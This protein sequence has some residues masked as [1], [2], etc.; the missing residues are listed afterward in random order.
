[1]Q[2]PPSYHDQEAWLLLLRQYNLGSSRIQIGLKRQYNLSLS[3]AIIP[4]VFGK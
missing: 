4:K 3:M 2:R 1:M